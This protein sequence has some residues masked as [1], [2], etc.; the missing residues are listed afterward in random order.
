MPGMLCGR[1]SC[2]E[3]AGGRT[4]RCVVYN[5]REAWALICLRNEKHGL[6]GSPLWNEGLIH[7]SSLGGTREPPNRLELP[8]EGPQHQPRMLALSPSSSFSRTL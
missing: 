1:C 2:L 8:G 7:L 3:R 5:I 4:F 6:R